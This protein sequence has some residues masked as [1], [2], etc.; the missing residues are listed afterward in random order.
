[1]SDDQLFGVVAS[2]A[3]LVFL[4][5]RGGL[6]RDPRRRRYAE[7]AAIGIVLAAIVYAG[8]M[9]LAWFLG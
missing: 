7:L 9:S 1:M 4:L 2:V 5:G 6:V 3:L 8:F